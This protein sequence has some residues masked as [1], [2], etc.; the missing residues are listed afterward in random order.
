MKKTITLVFIFCLAIAN[1]SLAQYTTPTHE[2]TLFGFQTAKGKQ[3]TVNKANDD[4]Y[5][6][7]RFGDSQKTDFEFP[8][9]KD[10]TS[11]QKF[12]YS[13]WIRGSGTSKSALDLKYL[14]FENEGYKYIIYEIYFEEGNTH[15]I[16]VRVLNL[17]T[18]KQTD[19]RGILKTQKGS[20]YDLNAEDR[21]PTSN[22]AYD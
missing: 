12:T 14:T 16:G 4:S 7:Y 9:V 22:A 21:I 19:I 1:S 13:S 6:V 11:F 8:Q 18:Q 2:I 15:S 10:S 17:A 20:L 3:V 5:L